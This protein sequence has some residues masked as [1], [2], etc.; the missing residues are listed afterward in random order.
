MDLRPFY[1]Y[2]I[3]GIIS[4][5]PIYFGILLGYDPHCWYSSC[6]EIWRF[7]HSSD[8]QVWWGNWLYIATCNII[9]LNTMTE[10]FVRFMQL[11][12]PHYYS[13]CIH[14]IAK[15]EPEEVGIQ[16]DI[17]MNTDLYQGQWIIGCWKL[18]ALY[19][20]LF[21][22]LI[23]CSNNEH[24]YFLFKTSSQLWFHFE[25]CY[26]TSLNKNRNFTCSFCCSFCLNNMMQIWAAGARCKW[27]AHPDNRWP[28]Q[29]LEPQKFQF[30]GKHSTTELSC[31]RNLNSKTSLCLFEHELTN[32]REPCKLTNNKHNIQ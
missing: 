25:M 15:Q 18:F 29:R 23:N 19:V 2:T 14:F 6:S 10:A 28:W 26:L 31:N 22:E 7:F 20:K 11:F 8:P 13:L 30:W 21:Y 27:R 4:L 24:V 3:G 12:I 17:T 32:Q 1:L 9:R 16:A 5:I